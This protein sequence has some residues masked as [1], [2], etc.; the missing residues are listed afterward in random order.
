MRA[1]EF[2][3]DM[4]EQKFSIRFEFQRKKTTLLASLVDPDSMAF[5]AMGNCRGG[6]MGGA[7]V[8]ACLCNSG[9]IETIGSHE[10]LQ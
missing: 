7:V 2:S 5:G 6:F 10:V 1:I 4:K 3:E 8:R 9:G